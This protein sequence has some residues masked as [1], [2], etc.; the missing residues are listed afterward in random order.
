MK[1]LLR[2]IRSPL[3]TAGV[4]PTRMIYCCDRYVPLGCRPHKRPN[5]LALVPKADR[6]TKGAL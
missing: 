5:V 4:H 6:R 1:A 2:I 3:L